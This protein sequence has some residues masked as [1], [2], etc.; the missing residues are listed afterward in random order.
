MS[1]GIAISS[2]RLCPRRAFRA[3]ASLLA[4][5]ASLGQAWGGERV[6][7]PL[8][9]MPPPA[10]ASRPP[11]DPHPSL[12]RSTGPLPRAAGLLAAAPLPPPA[13]KSGQPPAIKP[14]AHDVVQARGDAKP[15]EGT[16]REERDGKVWFYDLKGIGHP[17]NPLVVADLLV[18]KRQATTVQE[19]WRE[20]S[21]KAGSDPAAHMALAQQCIDSDLLAE[22]AAELQ[23]AIALDPKL[24]AA[25]LTLADLHAAQGQLD[26]EIGVYQAA[27]DAKAA[28]PALLERLGTRCIELGLLHT[29]HNAFAQAFQLAAK[30]SVADVAARQ[31]PVPKA[32]QARRLLRR[33]AEARVLQRRADA[34]PLLAL[35]IQAD[36]AD[37]A[38]RNAQALADTL[39]GRTQ[40]A[41]ETLRMVVQTPSPPPSAHNTLGASLFNAG[42]PAAALPH[43]LVCRQTLPRHPRATANAALALASLGKPA[44]AEDALATLTPPPGDLLCFWLA[45][46]FVHERQAR[47]DE[48][49]KAYGKARQTDRA[50]ADAASGLGRCLVAKGE[51]AAAALRFD[52]AR[53]LGADDFDALRGLAACH[54]RAGQLGQAAQAFREL[55][56]HPRAQPRDLLCL[57]ITLLRVRGSLRE[58]AALV[59]KATTGAQAADPYALAARAYLA[60]AGLLGTPQDAPALLRQAQRAAAAPEV[61]RYAAD[62]RRRLFAARGESVATVEFGAAGATI[63]PKG[64]SI[65]G[66]G[67]PAPEVSQAA[68]R[69][70]GTAPAPG[71][72]AVVW[73]GPR[74]ATDDKGNARAL[75]RF[76]A[77][78]WAPLTNDATVGVLLGVGGSTF[79]L[80]LRT[81]REPQLSRRLAYRIVQGPNATPWADLPGTIALERVGLGL[82]LSTRLNAAL[83]VWLDGR[84]VGEPVPLDV[85]ATLPPT[86]T[87]G[88]FAAVDAQQRCLFAAREIE[89]ISKEAPPPPEKPE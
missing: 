80:A 64:W 39:A 37:M 83:D 56:Q 43:F 4:L 50:S 60:N 22:A 7:L 29:A 49:A 46:G 88:V 61:A 89:L 12:Y 70:E 78:L 9:P 19:A 59:A 48:A 15:I 14:R 6:G 85:L 62:A 11:A 34:A 13:L 74:T 51:H 30:V 73:N 75:T 76:E 18:F 77:T 47:Y 54:F 38:A 68:L 26:A 3:V 52:E 67:G 57:A 79:Q 17:K 36:P 32:P 81:T 20:L 86:V 35:L 87:I 66:T 1:P 8:P 65:V 27:L 82:G 21:E 58:A 63:L 25:R 28:S 71:E 23:R 40:Q 53:L 31:E 16:I 55:A 44:E 72:R 5:L 33:V 69:F 24:E 2:G 45:A 42:D 41:I 10:V 84:T